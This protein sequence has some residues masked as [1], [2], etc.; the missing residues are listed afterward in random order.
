MRE[1]NCIYIDWCESHECSSCS[2]DNLNNLDDVP[3][4]LEKDRSTA[5]IRHLNEVKF[6]QR[7]QYIKNLQQRGYA[8]ARYAKNQRKRLKKRMNRRKSKRNK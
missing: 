4:Y 6:R 1:N 8:K 5:R 3:F 7:C 2:L